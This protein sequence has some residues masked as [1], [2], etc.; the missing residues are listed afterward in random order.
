[1]VHT[2]SDIKNV[3]EMVEVATHVAAQDFAKRGG[4]IVIVA[5]VPFGAEGTTNMLRVARV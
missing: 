3:A 1:M 2:K 4:Q 5:G